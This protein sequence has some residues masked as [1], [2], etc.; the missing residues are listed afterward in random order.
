MAQV[1]G[2]EMLTQRPNL[3]TNKTTDNWKGI[4]KV[5]ILAMHQVA[6]SRLSDKAMHINAC[7]L[8][9][10]HGSGGRCSKVNTET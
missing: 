3:V 10:L 4:S 1:A 9:G 6:C 7:T 8:Y 5:P 2:A